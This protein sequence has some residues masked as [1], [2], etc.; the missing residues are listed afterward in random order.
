MPVNSVAENVFGTIGTICWTVQLVPQL[1]K[2]YKEK[3]TEG[4]S[5]WLVLTWGI[6][7]AFLGAYSVVL[8]LN[9][10]LIV[11]PQC[12]GVL[13]ILS[14]A[15]CQYYGLKRSPTTVVLMTLGILAVMA[16]FETAMVFALRHPYNS[17]TEAGERGVQFLGIF[18]SVLISLAL[19]P[20]YFE[21]RRL[22]EVVGIS[23]SFM[24]VDLLGGVFSDLSLVFRDKFDVIAAITYSLVIVLDG[25]VI[26]AALILNPRAA[27]RRQR[28]LELA[29]TPS[30]VE[31]ATLPYSESR[32]VTAA[33]SRC[34]SELRLEGSEKP[35]DIVTGTT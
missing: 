29:A 3:S 16:G 4:L 11:Q 13:A 20:Q 1:W 5:P 34:P 24:V 10:P 15:Q 9:I 7:G 27:K 6:S 26:L 17:H 22:K 2:S 18:S 33:T 32:T 14:W 25:L 12:F 19:L 31:A 30:V 35:D 23:I 8:D 21:I 28:E